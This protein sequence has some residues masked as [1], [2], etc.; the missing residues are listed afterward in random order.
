MNG[1]IKKFLI[2]FFAGFALIY[3]AS[4]FLPV[5]SEKGGKYGLIFGIIGFIALVLFVVLF[6]MKT[7]MGSFMKSFPFADF[8]GFPLGGKSA[9]APDIPN[10]IA[11]WATISNF[12]QSGINMSMGTFQY[13]EMLIDLNVEG[14][15]GTTW[16]A[17]IKQLIPLAQLNMFQ[18]GMRIS[19]KYDPNDK[20]KVVLTTENPNRGGG[21]GSMDIPGYGT[22][23]SQTAQAAMQTAPR[24]ITL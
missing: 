4:F 5:L 14:M 20:S 9:E 17:R 12:Q 18:I 10:G 6:S 15:D 19:V 22:V 23:N 11:T 24:D 21:G 8:K 2:Y 1:Y 7:M 13:Y 3:I 16:P